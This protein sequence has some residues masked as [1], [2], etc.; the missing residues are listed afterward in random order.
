MLF[1]EVLESRLLGLR[2]L[3]SWRPESTEG[4]SQAHQTRII[5]LTDKNNFRWNIRSPH[6]SKYKQL[7]LGKNSTAE[8]FEN[9]KHYLSQHVTAMQVAT[10]SAVKTV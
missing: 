6:F 8:L 1:K 9:Y 3:L 4:C 2:E 5:P 10:K 7:S